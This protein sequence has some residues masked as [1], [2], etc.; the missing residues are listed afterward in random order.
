MIP[1]AVRAGGGGMSRA[2]RR[3]SSRGERRR[4]VRPCD[5]GPGSRWTRRA[6][7]DCNEIVAAK[8]AKDALLH[9]ALQ[10]LPVPRFELGGLVRL[11]ATRVGLRED[12]VADD[13]VVV[14]VRVEARPEAVQR[15]D[16][17]DLD[18]GRRRRSTSAIRRVL[19]E[20]HTPRS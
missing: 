16:G 7:G 9:R 10:L 5:V 3:S 4:A 19:H 8:V 15:R 1:V 17:A 11:Y 6:S 20:G 2:K 18:P 13:D 12:P 14:E